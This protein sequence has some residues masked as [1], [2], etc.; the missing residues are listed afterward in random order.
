MQFYEKQNFIMQKVKP[1]SKHK[2]LINQINEYFEI[3]LAEE[4]TTIETKFLDDLPRSIKNDAMF[5]KYQS[6]I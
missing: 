4:E 5:F 6:A 3:K 2:L 1:L